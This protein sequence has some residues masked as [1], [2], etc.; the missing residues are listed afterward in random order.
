MHAVIGQLLQIQYEEAKDQFRHQLPEALLF[1]HLRGH[2]SAQGFSRVPTSARRDR[3]LQLDRYLNRS[4]VTQHCVEHK[5][6]A[7]GDIMHAEHQHADE[8]VGAVAQAQTQV[9]S[10]EQRHTLLQRQH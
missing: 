6:E 5:H 4:V 1:N 9:F 8:V 7:G 3:A 2:S 10:D